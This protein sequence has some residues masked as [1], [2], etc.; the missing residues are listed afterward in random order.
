MEDGD[1]HP[2]AYTLLQQLAPMCIPGF[3]PGDI[4]EIS[5]TFSPKSVRVPGYRERYRRLREYLEL[6]RLGRVTAPDQCGD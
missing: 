1:R 5:L 3:R 2:V 4:D 6:S